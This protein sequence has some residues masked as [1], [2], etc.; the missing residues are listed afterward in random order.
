MES[1]VDACA[2]AA[3]AI[4]EATHLLIAAGAGFSADSGLP[5]Y[6][7]VAKSPAWQQ[8][9]LDYG[10][11]CSTQQLVGDSPHI[12]YGFW[13][14]CAGTYKDTEPHDG[15]SILE[16]WATSKP[17]GHTAVYTSNVDGHFRRF[18]ML[19]QQ[20]CEIHGCVEEW[21]CGASMG[22]AESTGDAR[23]G[24]FETHNRGVMERIREDGESQPAKPWEW[25]C[26]SSLHT[27]SREQLR[28]LSH[29]C[30]SLLAAIQPQMEGGFT[31][32]E[33]SPVALSARRPSASVDGFSWQL[34]PRCVGCG[35]PLRP[36]VLMFGDED[37]ALVGRLRAIADKYQSW[38]ERMEA[39]VSADAKNSLVVL[40]LGCGT[41]VP[42]VRIECEAV[43]HD[44]IERGGRALH[45]R[46]NP[47]G[48]ANDCTQIT[49]AGG[50]K[51]VD[52]Q[53]D[54]LLIWNAKAG[55]ALSAINKQIQMARRAAASSM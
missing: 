33:R 36:S 5:V 42:S 45:V 4:S 11:L 14:D 9:G 12:G 35:A 20:L 53:G 38:E 39:E 22:Y 48:G 47:E 46:I 18:P 28:E 40:E 54:S 49:N 6:A 24:A 30:H 3:A 43:C 23:P 1:E 21:A 8:L 32:A 26:A 37:P 16:S 29:G 17:Q 31:N 7:D 41:R 2:L 15:Y 10:D 51:P 34:P 50:P 27:P 55:A 25:P 13:T 52:P 44:T 19:S